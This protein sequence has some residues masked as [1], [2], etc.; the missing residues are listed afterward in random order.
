MV[1]VDANRPDA[2][3]KEPFYTSFKQWAR[4]NA[5]VPVAVFVFEGSNCTFLT[6]TGEKRLGA[7][8]AN[9]MLMTRQR[10]TANGLELDAFIVDRNSA[11]A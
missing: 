1:H 2:W 7:I 10:P 3:R 6:A 11:P 9:Q 5:G 4:G 8:G